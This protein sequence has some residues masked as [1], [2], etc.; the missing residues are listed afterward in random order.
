MDK[1][2]L[3]YDLLATFM[4]EAELQGGSIETL[5]TEVK[6]AIMGSKLYAPVSTPNKTS[7]CSLIDDIASRA[8]K[9]IDIERTRKS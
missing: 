3:L 9:L 5:S 2:D 8:Q 6:A 4:V 1:E 7:A